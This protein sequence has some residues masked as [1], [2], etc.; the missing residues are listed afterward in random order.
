MAIRGQRFLDALAEELRADPDAFG[1][2]DTM[3]DGADRLIH[4]MDE[5]RHDLAAFGPPPSEWTGSSADWFMSEFV[6]A[7]AGERTGIADA[8][9]RC[10]ATP[11]DTAD[12]LETVL[13]AHSAVELVCRRGELAT[14]DTHDV[15]AV[16]DMTDRPANTVVEVIERGVRYQGGLLRPARRRPT[17]RTGCRRQW[18]GRRNRSRAD[19][20]PLCHG[21][22]SLVE[23]RVF[24]CSG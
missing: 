15:V 19:R 17:S 9:V 3:R 4:A 10:S 1:L 22:G 14:P 23:D 21:N 24:I 8:F 13:S 2:R 7:V 18:T 12:M 5:L 6:T 20:R 11:R 16:D